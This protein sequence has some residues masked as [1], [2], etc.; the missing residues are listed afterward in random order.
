MLEW[1]LPS[2]LAIVLAWMVW[3][4]V[5]LKG[6]IETQARQL[7]Y[8]WQAQE[9]DHQANERAGNLFADWS[10][11]AEREI[12]QDA[13][14]KSHA[15]I[16]GHVTEHMVPYLSG[17]DYNP[18]DARF[19][20]TPV[21]FVIFDGLSEG[22]VR[23]IVFVEVKSGKRPAL[24]PRERL[25]RRCIREKRVAYDVLHHQANDQPLAREPAPG[26]DEEAP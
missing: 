2:L 13:I 1:L 17:F 24:S 12:R 6:Q 7:Y 26:A 11:A 16:R 21:D 8:H 20:G 5:R 23:R 19:L 4:Y 14:K 10:R 25:V 22:E 3:R 18:Q 9:M 15:V